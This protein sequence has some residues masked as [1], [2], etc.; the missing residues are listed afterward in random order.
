MLLSRILFCMSFS[1]TRWIWPAHCSLFNLIIFD[2]L[3]SSSCLYNS[4][5][6]GV[7]CAGLS[8]FSVRGAAQ[9]H[10]SRQVA[11]LFRRKFSFA[12]SSDRKMNVQS[13]CALNTRYV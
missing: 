5:A 1:S 10:F 9:R 11:Q 3:C 13:A 2:T 8:D 6:H 4:L 7:Q 12:G